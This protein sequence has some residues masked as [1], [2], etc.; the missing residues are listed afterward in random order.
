MKEYV[1]E[2]FEFVYIVFRIAIALFVVAAALAGGMYVG[3][4]ILGYKGL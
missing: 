1:K 3:L 2:F 4:K